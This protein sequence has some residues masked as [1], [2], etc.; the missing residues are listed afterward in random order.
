MEILKIKPILYTWF[1]EDKYGAYFIKLG[2]QEFPFH[3]YNTFCHPPPYFNFSFLLVLIDN[4]V[5]TG[6]TR[7]NLL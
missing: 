3:I 5:V 2:R 4:N 1:Y 6:I 7:L